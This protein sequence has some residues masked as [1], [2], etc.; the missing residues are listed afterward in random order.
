M[1]FNNENYGICMYSVCTLGSY[2]ELHWAMKC[3]IQHLQPFQVP[4]LHV[5]VHVHTCRHTAC[6]YM[7]VEMALSS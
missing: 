3:M 6:V 1:K 5:H 4:E 2:D 7:C